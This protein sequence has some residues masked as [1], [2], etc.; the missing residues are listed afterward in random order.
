MGI[1]VSNA[2]LT[3]QPVPTTP[4]SHKHRVGTQWSSPQSGSKSA[5]ERHLSPPLPPTSSWTQTVC[6][7]LSWSAFQSK[8]WLLLRARKDADWRM[9]KRIPL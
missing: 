4:T 5:R 3:A 8:E 2:A 9:D 1:Q 7:S 6:S